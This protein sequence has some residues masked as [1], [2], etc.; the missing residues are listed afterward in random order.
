MILLVLAGAALVGA[1]LWRVAGPRA[2]SAEH[3]A[4]V[5]ER[6][7]VRH[8]AAVGPAPARPV[9][10]VARRASAPTEGKSDRLAEMPQGLAQDLRTFND[11]QIRAEL[12]S[13]ALSFEEV[14]LVE[15]VCPTLPCRAEVASTEVAELNRFVEAVSNRFQHYLS[16]EFRRGDDETIHALFAIGV[17]HQTP[18]ARFDPG[19]TP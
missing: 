10:A 11:A 13:I 15:A 18:L 4:A 8:A 9:V 12:Q 7:D 2:S 19:S 6:D 14:E 5:V 17:P 16:T 3:E 1:V